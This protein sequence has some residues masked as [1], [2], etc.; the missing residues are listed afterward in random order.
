MANALLVLILG[1]VFT[2]FYPNSTPVLVL[3]FI[4]FSAKHR[5]GHLITKKREDF[6][7]PLQ[8][9]RGIRNSFVVIEFSVKLDQQGANQSTYIPPWAWEVVKG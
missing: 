3:V 6:R 5:Q 9:R 1:N 7:V 8:G 2:I 4:I